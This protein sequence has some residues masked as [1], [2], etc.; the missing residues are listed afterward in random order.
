MIKLILI[1]GTLIANVSFGGQNPSLESEITD[2]LILDLSEVVLDEHRKDFVVVHFRI[3]DD[4]IEIVQVVGTQEPL[5]QKVKNK[6]K[7]ISIHEAYDEETIYHFKFTFE[8]G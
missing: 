1:V 4:R 2:K 5:V 7:Q 6:L 8:Q 3:C